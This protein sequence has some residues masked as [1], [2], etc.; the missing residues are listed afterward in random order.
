[1]ENF[2]NT[3]PRGQDRIR[4]FSRL[5]L[6]VL[7][8]IV[9]FVTGC[10]ALSKVLTSAFKAGSRS[11]IH[12][13]A[14]NFNRYKP[15]TSSFNYNSTY[16]PPTS[17]FNYNST[18]KPPTFKQPHTLPH[19]VS[20]LDEIYLAT[21][22]QT[23]DQAYKNLTD[24]VLKSSYQTDDLIHYKNVSTNKIPLDDNS[25]EVLRI[26]QSY[27]DDGA[28]NSYSVNARVNGLPT[29]TKNQ[30]DDAITSV[31]N[32]HS[33]KTLKDLLTAKFG[34]NAASNLQGSNS[35]KIKQLY[36]KPRML[37]D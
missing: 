18:Y 22:N 29:L 6:V 30:V 4:F 2:N 12:R 9:P 3:H 27:S 36:S 17:S 31:S 11:G 23:D 20:Q 10:S 13:Q 32:M 28:I 8:L 7:L 26:I 19:S 33:E 1:M 15:P 25:K 34:N 24:R 37:D 16:K 14:S 35:Q 21:I 5:F